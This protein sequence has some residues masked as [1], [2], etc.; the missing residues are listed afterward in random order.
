MIC[1]DKWKT[2][3]CPLFSYDTIETDHLEMHP[4]SPLA[5]R[6]RR[7]PSPTP[8]R[9][10]RYDEPTPEP[11]LRPPP[12]N[13]EEEQRLRDLLEQRE[14]RHLAR[15][16]RPLGAD[17]ESAS[18]D[19]S[20]S[21]EHS[22]TS[23]SKRYPAPSADQYRRGRGILPPPPP[24]G[25]S[26]FD[27][28]ARPGFGSDIA[29]RI[30]RESSQERRLA[31]RFS[32]KR[33]HYSS[34]VIPTLSPQLMMPMGL[35]PMGPAAP[36]MPLSPYRTI[37]TGPP[38]LMRRHTVEEALYNGARTTR[39]SERIIPSRIRRDY[40]AEAA[41]HAPRRSHSKATSSS[42]AGLSGPGSGMHR[43]YEWRDHVEPGVPDGEAEQAKPSP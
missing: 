36:M 3:D 20:D 43:V 1:G 4:H 12:V 16:L 29:K 21:L 41:V 9:H 34:P 8:H 42:M 15:R 25:P 39:P 31:D 35:S 38:P 30:H 32:S 2:C 13:L 27:R 26:P 28:S 33:S 5:L 18:D 40:A 22:H 11:T 24:N 7:Y 17:E 37:M 10:Y 23:G 19:G 6:A 14:Q